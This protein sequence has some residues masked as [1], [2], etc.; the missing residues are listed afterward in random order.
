MAWLPFLLVIGLVALLIWRYGTDSR[1]G[2]DW[3]PVPVRIEPRV[4]AGDLPSIRDDA[5]R[6]RNVLRLPLN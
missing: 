3:Q 6:L 1:D 4:H 5:L 2:R